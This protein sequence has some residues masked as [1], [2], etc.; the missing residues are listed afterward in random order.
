VIWIRRASYGLLVLVVALIAMT[1]RAVSEGKAALEASDAAFHRGD[2]ARATLEARRAALAYAP[3]APH[4]RLAMARLR[5][6]AVGSQTA[7]DR[8]TAR[9]AWGAIRAA[10]VGTRHVSIPYT[11]ELEEANHALAGMMVQTG[12]DDPA[13]RA[14]AEVAARKALA[15]VPGPSPWAAL[16]LLAGA[17]LAA[18]GLFLVATRGVTRDGRVVGRGMAIG[19]AVLSLGVA[20]WTLAAYRA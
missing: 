14:R 11:A 13:A 16:P 3:G 18:A 4:T 8:E 12:L 7:G 19:L 5:A 9:L 10:A 6:I 2:L 15:S 20:F 1:L 17:T